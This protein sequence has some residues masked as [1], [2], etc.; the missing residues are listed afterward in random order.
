MLTDN[1]NSIGANAFEQSALTTITMPKA[2]TEVPENCF[3]GCSAL[4]TIGLNTGV[5]TVGKNA[6]KGCSSLLN[7]TIPANVETISESAFEDC[8]KLYNVIFNAGIKYIKPRAF[9][10]TTAL[11]SVSFPY[12]LTELDGTSF[13]GSGLKNVTCYNK[14]VASNRTLYPSGVKVKTVAKSYIQ[15]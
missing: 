3:N 8:T 15:Q 10:N 7:I 13:E 5:K 4:K 14:N 12:T 1:I 6:F 11:T 9:A 2:L